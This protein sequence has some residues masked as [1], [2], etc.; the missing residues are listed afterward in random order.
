MLRSSFAA[1]T[2]AT[3]DDLSDSVLQSEMGDAAH[4]TSLTS[5]GLIVLSTISGAVAQ[6][7]LR[8]GAESLGEGG[9]VGLLTNFPL[10]GGYTCLAMNVVLV[11]LAFRG[12]QLSVLYPIIALTYVWVA[13]LSPMYFPEAITN[14]QIAGLALIIAGV[15]FI[16]AGS[17]S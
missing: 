13:I 8:F 11:V 15:S 12:G 17:R 6:I 7:L 2:S 3:I 1:P 5:I 16:G 9:L 14:S 10:M 4:Q